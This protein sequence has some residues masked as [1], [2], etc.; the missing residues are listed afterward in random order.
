MQEPMQKPV[1]STPRPER[2]RANAPGNRWLAFGLLLGVI[3]MVGAAYAAVPLYRMFCQAT[4]YGG[5][6][7]RALEA[8]GAVGEKTVIV[9]FDANV[10]PDLAWSFEPVQREVTLKFGEN[11]LAFFRA[12]NLSSRALAGTATFNVSPG[13]AGSYFD[14]IQC[15]CFTEQHLEPGESAELPVSFFVD[16]AML[17]DPDAKDIHEITLSYTF[18]PAK[19]EPPA[20]SAATE[21]KAAKGS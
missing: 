19:N 11:K 12:K 5:T 14:K 1:E 10:S 20:S 15:F 17:K 13:L 8:P 7:Q 2:P 18:F 9:R 16:P 3:A 4:G 21:V 6:T